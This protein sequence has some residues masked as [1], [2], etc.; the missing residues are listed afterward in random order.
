MRHVFSQAS[1][2]QRLTVGAL[3][4]SFTVLLAAGLILSHIHRQ[5][6]ERAF[7][8]RLTVYLQALSGSLASPLDQDRSD[9]SDLGDPKFDL[10]MSGWYWQIEPGPAGHGEMIASPSLFLSLIHI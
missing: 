3:V 8:E 5:A 1:L 7:D 9:P 10:P 6:T 2:A 4:S